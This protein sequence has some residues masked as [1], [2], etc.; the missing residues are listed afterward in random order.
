MALIDTQEHKDEI[1][2]EY[3]KSLNVSQAVTA[4]TNRHAAIERQRRMREEMAATADQQRAAE[5]TVQRAVEATAPRPIKE[6]PAATVMPPVVVERTED[7]EPP[8]LYSAA[9]RVTGSL[10]QLKA[11]KKFL[12]DGGYVY[13]QLT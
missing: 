2:V 12:V 1:L 6:E 9:F 7:A 3:R 5:K 10:D 8:K 11:L 4:V 13:E